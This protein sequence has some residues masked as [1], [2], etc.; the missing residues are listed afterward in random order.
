V[1]KNFF[2]IFIF[3]T[4]NIFAQQKIIILAVPSLGYPISYIN[5]LNQPS[6]FFIELIQK[7]FQN[8]NYKLNYKYGTFTECLEFIKNG[9]A[10]LITMITYSEER[11]KY[12]SFNNE[13]IYNSWTRVIIKNDSK[14]ENILDLT[15]KNIGIVFEDSNGKEFE[16][17]IKSFGIKVNIKKYNT[18]LDI[19]NAIINNNIDAG[20]TTSLYNILNQNIISSNIV[21]NPTKSFVITKLNENL[22]ILSYID[23][24]L[25]VIKNNKNSYYYDLI[26]KYFTRE[27]IVNRLSP[28]ILL[29]IGIILIIIISYNWLLKNQV[30]KKTKQLNEFNHNLEKIIKERSTELIESEKMASLGRTVAGFAH[31]I[32]TPIGVAF[33]ASSFLLNNSKEILKNY[34][35][36]KLTEEKFYEYLNNNIKTNDIIN[37]NL[38]RASELICSLR[39]ISGNRDGNDKKIINI[40]EYFDIILLSLKPKFKNSNFICTYDINDIIININ[41]NY[42]FGI[43]TNLIVNSIDHGF[44]NKDYGNIYVKIFKKDDNIYIIY[45]DDGCGISEENLTKVFEPF[46]TTKRGNGKFTGLGLS[47]VYNIVEKLN[48]KIEVKNIKPGVEFNIAIKEDIPIVN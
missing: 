21:F 24:E 1:K 16:L 18:Y 37:L 23:S 27:V 43:F 17:F 46:F 12:F 40:K 38:N 32:N 36:G 20:V 44:E 22:D 2:L 29:I 5:E 41:P 28:P 8:S 34:T 15:D 10:D 26:N 30:Y 19:E 47:I 14:I 4:F 25:I 3:I 48:G 7:I 39:D 13:Y 33:T 31:E 11:S 45:Q 35:E 9:E 6:G 42:V